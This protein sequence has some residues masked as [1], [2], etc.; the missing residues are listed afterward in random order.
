MSEHDERRAFQA[1][2]EAIRVRLEA[3]KAKREADWA[4]WNA[5]RQVLSW[6][7]WFQA[8]AE[9][10]TETADW[11]TKMAGIQAE[12]EALEDEWERLPPKPVDAATIDQAATPGGM[13]GIESG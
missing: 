2:V 11:H 1:K 5:A 4:K 10:Q 8:R 3:A 12:A 6:Q 7:V 9:F 13:G